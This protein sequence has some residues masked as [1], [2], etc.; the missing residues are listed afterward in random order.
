MIGDFILWLKQFWKE[1]TCVHNYVPDRLGIITGCYLGRVCTK[2][3][4]LEGK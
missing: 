2:C 1:H 4:R 3:G